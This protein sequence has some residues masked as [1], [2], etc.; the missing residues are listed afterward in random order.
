M[1]IIIMLIFSMIVNHHKPNYGIGPKLGIIQI[2]CFED[3]YPNKNEFA[4]Q[5]IV[6]IFLTLLGILNNF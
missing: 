3:N 5:L 2:N 6:K 1:I 4:T